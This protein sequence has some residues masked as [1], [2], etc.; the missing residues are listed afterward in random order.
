M[1]KLT[2]NPLRFIPAALCLLFSLLA[3]NARAGSLYFDVN[4]TAATYG[5]AASGS[6]SWDAAYWA[7]A[8]GGTTATAAWVAGSFARFYGANSYTVTVNNPE[9][10]AGMAEASSTAGATLTLN[11]AGSGSLSV[12]PS[13]TL[14]TGLPTQ[15]FGATGGQSAVI[16][17]PIIGSG[18][19]NLGL[20]SGN[21]PNIYL[22]GNNTYSGGT[23]LSSSSVLVYYNNNNSFG[24]GPINI[25]G[26]TMALFLSMGGSPITLANNWT[27]ANGAAGIDFG[28]AA[29][30]P[31]TCTG[32]L[33]LPASLTLKNNGD[34]T[35][36][37]TWSGKISG[38]GGL[39]MQGN[40][41]GTI[42]LSGPNTYSGQTI[43]TPTGPTL[44]LSVASLNSVTTPAQQASSSLGVPANAANGTIAIGSGANTGI[45]LYTGVGETSDRIIN[46][47][48]TTGG[49]TLQADGAGA[50]VL[51]A[52]NT[53][54]GA[55][56]K[57][58]TLQGSNLD[59]NSIGKIVNSSS[60]TAVV[61]A[62]G[63]WWVLT[64]ANTYTGGTTVN[65][66]TLEI[67][68]SVAG[69][70]THT[71][72]ILR[73]DN[74]SALSPSAVVSVSSAGTV[75][76]N[77]SGTLVVNT[78]I[79]DG[80]P[81]YSGIWG[82]PTSTAPP[83]NQNALFTGN[84]LIQVVSPPIITQQPQSMSVY[85]DSSYTF[86]A[87][88]AGD[89]S[90]TYQWT[91][92]GAPVS[93]GTDATLLINP[94]ETPNAG[95]YVLWITNSI[96]WTNT[97]NV[98]LTILATNDY[99]NM[100]RGSFP[101]ATPPIA[102]WRLDETSGTV[103][104]D[105]IG[106]HTGAYVNANLNHPGFSAVPGSDPA[107]GVPSNVSLKG[108]MVI[109]N[110][111]P[112]FSFSPAT[113]FTLEAWAMS[114]NFASGIK[115]RIISYLTL[116]GNG[117]YGFGFPD[118]HTLQ[119]TAGGVADFN[120]TISPSLAA[121]VWYHFVATFDGNN[122][123]FY[124]N[125]NP[126]GTH[127]VAGL[128]IQP[129]VG[130]MCVGNNPLTYPTEQLYGAI[131]EVAI[132]DYALDQTTVTNH[133]LARYT[134]APLSVSAPVVTPPTNYVS[135]SSTLT[136][137]AAGTGLSYVWYH[138]AGFGS[139]VGTDATL[140]LSSLQLS[141]AGY[142]HV[143]VTDAGFH[144]ADSPLVY[145][146][147]LP[148][149]TSASDL[150]LTNGLVLHLPFDSD[151]KDVSG[152][153]NDGT[154]VGSPTIAA[155]GVIGSGFLQYGTTNG[156][157]TNYVTVGVRPDLQFGDLATGT[158]FTVAYWVRGTLNINLPIFCDATGGEAG[159]V[160]LHGG[161]Y[162]GPN[163]TGNGG[164]AVGVGSALH[165]M[166]SSGPDIINDGNW[167]SLVY[168]C[169]RSGSVKTY[170]NGAELDNHPVS[171]VT[172]TINT[173]N[174]AN[175]GQDGTGGQVFT[176]QSGD[177]DDLAVW[178]RTLTDLEVSGIYLAGAS[179]SVSFALPAPAPVT[180][181]T[182]VVGSTTLS[183][184]GGAGSQFVLLGTNDI[185]APLTNWTR[186]ATNSS[187]PGSFTIPA[188]GSASPT[189]YRI[190]SE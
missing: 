151:Y 39:T 119:F 9:S 121:G 189:F 26:T 143:F 100:I 6:Y 82:S 157:S 156:V 166:T 34:S 85:P 79:I 101:A 168:V 18:G 1:K 118:N 141:D 137:V 124:L 44:T 127:A 11:A 161:Y 97:I 170:L 107:M 103:A 95:T 109:S 31:V 134:D 10:M 190:Q 131:D 140:T 114:T 16:N 65:G 188:V 88:V 99:V 167:H 8:S 36:G 139:Q 73:L 4:G 94:V 42:T 5:T 21:Y 169:K 75:D 115:Q 25:N 178:T 176:D 59:A 110:A 52:V 58:L 104:H 186:L 13:G 90:F 23:T 55:G 130:P 30:T 7:T 14:T 72:G 117:G 158:D 66:G 116:T 3:N 76:L 35:A 126:V 106:G 83:A 172:D 64:G 174:P 145:L 61:K 87:V 98:T 150:N 60:A 63:S 78:L 120:M 142:Y 86:S 62:Q 185:T 43:I 67:S 135:L 162:F 81:I 27:N 155:T 57:T 47:A 138:G 53:A 15:L 24:T 149:P 128:A 22:Y 41:S 183:Y 37:L 51:T 152:R 136:A 159:I 187:T 123:F 154:A 153:S 71:A 171:F 177:I 111:S 28:N 180:I 165:E 113:P 175:I 163:T 179:N 112:T 32:P 93:G 125:G 92:N 122:Y 77:Y 108:Y 74:A 38:I 105:W 173:A 49:A 12:V 48:G 20:Y 181:N 2:P 102:Y 129:P 69:N 184:T 91:L 160:L 182:P 29:N 144:T 89:P 147:V 54:T 17:A 80:T 56:S 45:L 70:V 96:G 50:L 132:Y 148:I 133:Y 40:N 68:G 164:W 19:V 46:L 146:A 33:S 84:G